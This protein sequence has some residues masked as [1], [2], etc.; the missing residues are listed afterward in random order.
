[1]SVPASDAAPLIAI[2]PKMPV[3]GAPPSWIVERAGADCVKLPLTVIEFVGP[4]VIVP[5]LVRLP[6]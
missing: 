3:D 5:L 2:E 1:M 4:T 6:S